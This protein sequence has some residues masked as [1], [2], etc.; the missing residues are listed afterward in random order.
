ML[1]Y[2]RKKDNTVFV[3]FESGEINAFSEKGELNGFYID[4][5]HNVMSSLGVIV[6]DSFCGNEGKSVVTSIDRNPEGVVS[7]VVVCLTERIQRDLIEQKKYES[8]EDSSR[9]I[10]QDATDPYFDMIQCYQFLRRCRH[11]I[12]RAR[13]ND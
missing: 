11:N 5:T 3:F 13:K 9:V 4:V 6:N 8:H 12:S 1:G 7:N 2:T 10:L